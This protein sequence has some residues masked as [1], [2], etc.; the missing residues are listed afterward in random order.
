MRTSMI[1]LFSLSFLSI[2]LSIGLLCC[3]CWNRP[4]FASENRFFSA[5]HPSIHYTGRVDFSNPQKPKIWASGAY[6]SLLFE[7]SSCVLKINDEMRWGTQLNYL[8]IKI[9]NQPSRRIQ[10]KGKENEVVLASGLNE[11]TH[12]LIVCKNSE[13]ENGYIEIGGFFCK[14]LLTPLQ[15]PSR[16]IEFIGDSIT[17][18]AGSDEREIACGQGSWH[19]QHNAW[20]AYGP[21]TA[22]ELKAEWHLTSVSGI[23]L[24]HSCCDKKILMPQVYDKIN[25][26]MDSIP[27]NFTLYQPDVLTICL[28]QN[29]GIQDSLLFC[30]AYVDFVTKLRWHYPQT[31]FILLT[32][33]MADESLKAVQIRYLTAIKET[34]KAKGDVRVERYFFQKSYR[35]GCGGHPSIADHQEMAQELSLFLRNQMKWN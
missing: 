21:L 34:L 1:R 12:S 16:K 17:C 14:N 4:A 11:G 7:G 3:L 28:G 10:L 25:P 8:E 2:P 24:M 26:A 31:T 22:R 32:S 18:G 15:R 9:D 27:W 33:P 5:D 29:D 20:S 35:R 23:G 19:D 30:K 6:I 13:A